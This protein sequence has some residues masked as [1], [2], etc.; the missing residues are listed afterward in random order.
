M[1]IKIL[2]YRYAVKA[3]IFAMILAVALVA[4]VKADDL[5]WGINAANGN[6]HIN[7]IDMTTG[8]VIA[9]FIVPNPAA[10]RGN[11]RGIAVAGNTVYYSLANSGAI[12]VTNAV[13]HA[14]GGVLF[15]TGLGGVA[16]L[17][18]D[19]A[20]LWV[21][22][23][24]GT[25]NVYKYDL[26]GN[27]LATVPGFGNNRDGLEVLGNGIIANRGDGEG[28]YDLYDLSGN[29]VKSAFI[30]PSTTPAFHGITTG[31]TFNGTSYFVSNP[32]SYSNA[33]NRILQFDAGGNFVT[34]LTLPSP[35]PQPGWLL[36]DLSSLGNTPS[37]PPPSS[38]GTP[39]P[40]TIV[41][42]GAGLFGVGVFTRHRRQTAG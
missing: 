5:V 8:S 25:D 33:G 6:P 31:V 20:N 16:T 22:A 24:D 36:E 14:D 7:E 23:Y 11:G 12:Y 10:V 15:N 19:G 38:S 41:L 37:N 29:L 4:P 21:S 3:S 17:T 9:D 40:S 39:E 42:L 32:D 35:G 18:W 30:N 34:S 2:E 28:P 13:T 26:N 27:K 1:P